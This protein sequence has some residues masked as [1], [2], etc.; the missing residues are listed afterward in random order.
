[1]AIILG[2]GIVVRLVLLLLFSFS[3]V[4]WGIIL[5][6][7]FQVQRANSESDRF[8]DFFW[9]SKRFDAIASQVDRFANS[10]LTV[11]FNEGYSELKKV[12]ESMKTICFSDM[13]GLN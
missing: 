4:S 11:L 9:K 10:P 7:F 5:F 6:K 2:A 12:V 8:M 1:M 13:L 3:V